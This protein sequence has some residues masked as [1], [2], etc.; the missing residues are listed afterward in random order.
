[1]TDFTTDNRHGKIGEKYFKQYL[2]SKKIKFDDVSKDKTMQKKDVDFIVTNEDKTYTYYEVKYNWKKNGYLVIEIFSNC[3]EILGDIKMGW[4]WYC[5]AHYI[6]FVSPVGKMLQLT[7]NQ[8]FKN[9]FDEIKNKLEV[10]INEPTRNRFGVI[11][12]QSAYVEI[13][14]FDFME[15]IEYLN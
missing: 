10:H 5:E 6:I 4:P 13:P 7:F 15:F 1:M 12:H 2:K 8:D 9:K 3:N 14:I 11:T